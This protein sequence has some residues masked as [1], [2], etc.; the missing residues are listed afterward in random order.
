MDQ[1]LINEGLLEEG[2]MQLIER[3]LLLHEENKDIES[4]LSPEELQE[5]FSGLKHLVNKGYSGLK[6]A[7]KSAGNAAMNKVDQVATNVGNSVYDNTVGAAKK[8][9]NNIS[10]AASNVAAST[11]KAVH[12]AQDKVVDTYKQGE[13]NGIVQK[14]HALN[15]KYKEL[16][17]KSFVRQFGAA[18]NAI[19][20][21]QNRAAAQP[22]TAAQMAMAE[23]VRMQ[24]LAGLN[25]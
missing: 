18:A 21:A 13:V 23:C 3:A 7:A 16:T 10:T 20:N 2:K 22:Q 15:S 11:K 1:E 4:E 12:G 25:G 19:P 6:T 9:A 14:I 17:G 24:H 8:A 5:L